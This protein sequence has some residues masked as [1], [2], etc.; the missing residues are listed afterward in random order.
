MLRH[1]RR[2]SDGR[3]EP[4]P[5]ADGAAPHEGVVRAC[6]VANMAEELLVLA[7][8]VGPLARFRMNVGQG[9]LLDFIAERWSKGLAVY[10]L[11]PK[12]RQVGV[13]TFVQAFLFVL[14]LLNEKK[15]R[16]Y[17]AATV[18]HIEDSAKSIFSMTRLF[19]RKLPKSWRLPLESNQQGRI[20]W[21]GG[22]RNQVVSAKLGDAALKGVTLNAFHGS[23]VANWADLGM[24]PNAL[25][26][27]AWGAVAKT[28]DAFVVLESTAKGRD[29]FFH[30]MVERSR[31]NRFEFPVVFIPWFL[32][33]EYT[34]SWAA[35]CSA[36][37][38]WHLTPEFVP[39]TD[40]ILFRA[41]LA[42][43]TVRPGDEWCVYR[44]AL[45]DEQLIWRR[46][47]IERLGSGD[48][49]KGLDLFKR[50]FPSTL[51]ECWAANEYSFLGD[52]QNEILDRMARQKRAP[53]RGLLSD[54]LEWKASERT[55]AY[56]RWH[57][58]QTGHRYVI[59]ADCSEGVASG[60][61]QS[62][63]VVD[64]GT[65]QVVAALHCKMDPD[66]FGAALAKLGRYYNNALLAVENN[67]APTVLVTL[68]RL[69]YPKVYW[70]RDP[71][72]LRGRPPKPGF[73]TNKRTR[74]VILAVLSAVLRDDDLEFNDEGFFAE[75]GTFVWSERKQTFT[76]PK[77]YH[78]DRILSLAIAVYVCDWRDAEGK[79]KRSEVAKA[80]EDFEQTDRGWLQWKREEKL[81]KQR[82]RER[83]GP[84]PKC[85][86]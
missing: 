83:A 86:L 8:K 46:A 40:E 81:A 20:E 70:H 75:C 68:T 21:A 36:R 5:L 43:R 49:T 16:P 80:P 7:P 66:E 79:R 30:G 25:W 84:G 34:L 78:D 15:G 33:T 17:R 13:S 18:A 72:Q 23:E 12:A 82:A 54:N 48:T 41:F 31:A 2:G 4:I 6:L 77:G 47:E 44:Y 64:Q 57:T 38:A 62:A 45:T 37:P 9:I 22:S 32:M 1:V 52:R 19:E 74:P 51:E 26:S 28:P 65:H 59:G 58:P 11:I 42:D 29:P 35:Y 76:A 50:Y 69:N 71:D 3:W 10:A 61:F 14:C 55:D 24:D 73:N 85:S 39:T 67:F 63:H 56:L 27:S 53:Q 60:D